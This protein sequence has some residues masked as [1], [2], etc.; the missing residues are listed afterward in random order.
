MIQTEKH[1]TS[2][3]R[4]EFVNVNLGWHFPPREPRASWLGR[5]AISESPDLD[6]TLLMWI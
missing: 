4:P 3:R 2:T 5:A 1:H 6:E